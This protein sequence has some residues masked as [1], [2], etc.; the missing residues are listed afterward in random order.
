MNLL[1]KLISSPGYPT[2]IFFRS[3]IGLVFLSEGIQKFITPELTGAG[4]FA[5]I[6]IPNPEFFGPFVGSFE[7]ICG[8][9]LL[10]GFLTRLASIPLLAIICVAIY[11]TKLSTFIEKG[12]WTT[13][14][15]GRT[16]FCIFIGL[17]CLLTYGGGKWSIDRLI[18]E[19][20]NENK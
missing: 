2:N 16:D 4:R 17:I 5:K 11:T 9:L 15:E 8:T 6:G 18:V 19:N 1:N 14:H 13:A 10:L 7:I 12:F 3:M 20:I